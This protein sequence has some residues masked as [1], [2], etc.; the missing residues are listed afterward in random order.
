MVP[1]RGDPKRRRQRL[2][3]G[4]RSA[5]R[6]VAMVGRCTGRERPASSPWQR[7]HGPPRTNQRLI[8]SGRQRQLGT[9]RRGR[10][11][12]VASSL[13][14]SVH[15]DD[16]SA[17]DDASGRTAADNATVSM[18]FVICTDW[19]IKAMLIRPLFQRGP[20]PVRFLSVDR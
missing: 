2:T 20:P 11:R 12:R 19:N 9:G 6:W 5:R 16:P 17:A 1:V 14:S 4:G 3:S 13:V 7:P 18:I 10:L 15:T 8:T